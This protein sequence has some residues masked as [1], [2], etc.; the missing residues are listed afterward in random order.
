MDDVVPTTARLEIDGVG[1]RFGRNM[2]LDDVSISISPGEIRGVVGRNGAGKSTLMDVASGF[3]K[4]DTGRVLVNGKDTSPLTLAQYRE[5]VG[6][7]H[8]H[9]NLIK[10][11]SIAENLRLG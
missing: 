7:V 6:M 11:L 1:K 4:P 10:S 9:S 5:I 8:Q 2:A 3:L